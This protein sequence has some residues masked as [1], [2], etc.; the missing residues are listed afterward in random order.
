MKK[1]PGGLW[2]V[3]LT[4]FNENNKLDL[5]GLELL[6]DFYINSG[7]DGLFANC[8]S[9]EMFELDAEERLTII[10]TITRTVNGKIPII[11]TGTFSKNIKENNKFINQAYDAGAS[12]LV[13]N[14]NQLNDQSDNEDEFREKLE[15][16]MKKTGDIPLG[17]YECPVPYKRLISPGIMKW[18]AGSGRFLYHKDTS[19]ELTDIESK[20]EA[21]S[22]T[23]LGLYNANTPTALES[24]NKGA[25]GLSTIGANFFP[26]LYTYLIKNYNDEKQIARIQKINTFLCVADP[27]VHSFYPLSAKKF[28]QKRGLKIN[29]NTRIR[30]SSMKSQDLIILNEL[31]N[32]FKEI[33]SQL[34]LERSI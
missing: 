20:I 33:T 23:G 34:N 3:M 14:T 31:M 25:A 15:E 1:L 29:I 2:P 9:S 30:V 27:I 19:C 21:I 18:A 5:D 6:I 22:G 16:L 10:K 12:A 8:L 28:L 13:I 11:A 4:P 24:M 26:E 17:L 32:L 7:A